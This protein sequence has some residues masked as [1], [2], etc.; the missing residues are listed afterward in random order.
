MIDDIFVSVSVSACASVLAPVSVCVSVFVCLCLCLR[1]GAIGSTIFDGIH[2][3][4][5]EERFACF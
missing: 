5:R 1:T 2:E 4:F 3:I